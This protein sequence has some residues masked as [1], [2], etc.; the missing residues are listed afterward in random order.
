MSM[1]VRVSVGH[2]CTAAAI[3]HYK[4][5]KMSDHVGPTVKTSTKI[6]EKCSG[7]TFSLRVTLWIDHSLMLSNSVTLDSGL[8]SCV[9]GWAHFSRC[10]TC[11]LW[12]ILGLEAWAVCL[13]HWLHAGDWWLG[14]LSQLC[15]NFLPAGLAD[16]PNH[17][18]NI[19]ISLHPAPVPR[20]KCF[21]TRARKCLS[22]EEQWLLWKIIGVLHPQKH[23]I[24]INLLFSTFKSI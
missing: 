2:V 4:N 24:T 6:E 5:A 11:P 14:E 23:K 20:S 1:D 13:M 10:Q 18:A 15:S 8:S 3:L 7:C 12:W 17:L 16:G 21:E 9:E 22:I 19:G